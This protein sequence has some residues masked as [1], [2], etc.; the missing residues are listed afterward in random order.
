MVNCKQINMWSQ[1][2]KKWS[3]V[4]IGIDKKGNALFIFTR[5][6]YSGHDF[7][8]ILLSLDISL[9]NAMYLEGGPE[10]SFYLTNGKFEIE[11]FGS[12]ETNFFLSDDNNEAWPIPNVI[13]IM[14]KNEK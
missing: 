12:F 3:M 4:V 11:K 2:E 13:G 5:S 8:D 1:Q 14:K 9:Y 10:A 6:P 7:I